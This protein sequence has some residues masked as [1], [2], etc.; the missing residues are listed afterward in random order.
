[1]SRLLCTC[2]A[3]LLTVLATARAGAQ[4]PTVWQK[5]DDDNSP[6]RI[7]EHQRVVGGG[8]SGDACEW[9]QIENR[10]EASQ[11]RLARRVDHARV[12]DDL[13]FE[14][15]VKSDRLGP[16]LVVRIVLPN[17]TD[18]RSGR[19]MITT[20]AGPAYTDL[21]RWQSL[22]LTGLPALLTQ[23]I[24]VLRM[25]AGSQVD[26]R[27][28]YVDAVMLSAY[29]GAGVTNLWIG[30]LDVTGYAVTG[31]GDGAA[32]PST[33]SNVAPMVPVRA[34]SPQTGPNPPVGNAAARRV[35][36]LDRSI[37]LV[38]DRPIFPRVIQHRG[39]PLTFL[40]QLG[41]NA[42]W[43]Q[44]LPAP[45]ML[46]EAGRIG[47][48][49][50][51]PPPA[52]SQ[53][54][55]ADLGPVFDPVLAW[56]LGSELTE[57][58]LDTTQRWAE[59]I[60]TADRRVRRPLVCAPKANLRGYSRPADLL[61][62]DRR[63]LG[64]S[65]QLK[66]YAAWVGQQPLLARPGTPVWTTVQTQPNESTR[67]QW[68]AMDP[69]ASPPKNASV[70]QIQ[71]L[72]YTA[73]ASGSRGLVFLSDSPLD[74]DDPE[75]RRRAMALEWLN[76]DLELLEPWAAAGRILASA[77]SNVPQ[78]E[79]AVLLA[80]RARLLLPIWSAPMSQYTM[81]QSAA[82]GVEILAPGVP[83]ANNA[84]ELS[85]SGA[86]PL[87]RQRVAGGVQ[88]TLD[89]FGP[90][91]QVLLAHDPLI[92][93]V[94]NRRAAA[95]GR[96]AAT[97]QRQLAV[98][99]F[100]G[101]Q[102]TAQLLASHSSVPEAPRWFDDARRSLQ[103]CDAQ[104]SAGDFTEAARNAQRAMRSLRRIER[105]YWDAAV[106]RLPSP[107]TSPAAVGFG[108]LPLHWRLVDRL[109][110][111]QFGPNRIAGG[112]FEDLDTMVRAGWRSVQ[113][114]TPTLQT[115]A[116]L[117]PSAARTGRLGLR[118]AAVATDPKQTPAAMESPPVVFTSPAVQVEAG[119]TVCVYGWVRV[120]K[121]IVGSPDG[122]LIVDS[123]GGEA[124]ADRIAKTDDWRQFALYRIVP[125]AGPFSVTFA[126]GGVG[127]AWIDDVV[128]QVLET[129][130]R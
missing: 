84:Y 56:D 70:E 81:P 121:A 13:A 48:W 10:V 102:A 106:R 113:R 41:F 18:P 5:T 91:A 59:Q 26:G 95:S 127:E 51:C 103:A 19:P 42:V 109:N 64:T 78:V 3:I 35:V 74:A 126:L 16:Q 45:E 29:G 72:A 2:L 9:L 52:S 68:T 107:V 92:V 57:A 117:S 108:T 62:I 33:P 43:L 60:K 69:S 36:K 85:P 114:S 4:G 58:E 115:T 1:M 80:E 128:I 24:H 118:L 73:V 124:L 101:V 105:A 12:I 46:E 28:A 49:L 67:R 90:S 22:R 130:A 76:L 14:V 20:L 119:Q 63:P 75:T 88:V 120:D 97:L 79:G 94:V 54:P 50:I 99:K 40:K 37:L 27:G 111:A 55:M 112:D 100:S 116:D 8:R 39:E 87:R 82:N 21:G 125:Q 123:L 17:T 61:L 15:W 122:L 96:R 34:P 44:R 7:L 98:Q 86:L 89:E 66:D 6:Y 38:N 65:M 11:V 31:A 53:T 129:P 71:L 93:D 83:E 23:Q 47:L 110:G 25:Q 77:A 30:D 104:L 32:Q